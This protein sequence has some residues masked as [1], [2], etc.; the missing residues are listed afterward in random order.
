MVEVGFNIVIKK[1]GNIFLSAAKTELLSEI[2]KC[3]SLI[4]AAKALKI[5]YQHAWNLI[6]DMNRV[7]PEPPIVKQRGG[8]N[9]GGATISAYGERVLREYILI[10]A[11]VA[12]LVK[13]INV[14]IN[15]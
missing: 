1:D 11:Q 9:G 3:G 2:V 12:N 10:E 7:A 4:G 15:L 14:E 5:S 6:D 13:M 8:A